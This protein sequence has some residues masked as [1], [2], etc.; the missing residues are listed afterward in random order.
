MPKTTWSEHLND[1]MRRDLARVMEQLRVARRERYL[2]GRDIAD[3]ERTRAEIL[4]S[5]RE[6]GL[7]G[8]ET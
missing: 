3:L 4:D 6:A 7:A 1:A 8:E 2:L 5:M